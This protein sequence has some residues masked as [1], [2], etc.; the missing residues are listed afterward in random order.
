MINLTF[1]ERE[2]AWIRAY[3]NKH[4]VSPEAAVRIAVRMFSLVEDV[5]GAR[6]AVMKIAEERLGPKPDMVLPIPFRPGV[7]E[8]AP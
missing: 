1:S 8:S 2:E 5:P 4:Q 7:S 3:A 6:D